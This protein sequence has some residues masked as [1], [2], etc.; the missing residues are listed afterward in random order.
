LCESTKRKI[1]LEVLNGTTFFGLKFS[2]S[3]WNDYEN[4]MNVR[5]VNY[6]NYNFVLNS[7]LQWISK[8]NI[9]IKN[10]VLTR[11]D[12]IPTNYYSFSRLEYLVVNS[13]LDFNDFYFKL[14]LKTCI[15]LK[16]LSIENC[17]KFYCNNFVSALAYL[18]KI[19][20][21]SITNCEQ[22]DDDCVLSL[23]SH[24]RDLTEVYLTEIFFMNLPNV[25]NKHFLFFCQVF[26][27][28]VEL[29]I[30]NCENFT[31]DCLI[32]ISKHCKKLEYLRLIDLPNITDEGLECFENKCFKLKKIKI[33]DCD[34]IT[35]ETSGK[36]KII[37]SYDSDY[38]Y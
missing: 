20:S 16:D 4:A 9:F 25:T 14:L 31:N 37:N 26:K 23:A 6:E 8:R 18:K 28:L 13:K 10:F 29:T 32:S 19:K 2:F 17:D 27:Y 34:N 7:Y 3:T 38:S 30:G 36:I 1:I 15:N 33:I 35:K 22:F 12:V 21:L 24:Y 5:A 11:W